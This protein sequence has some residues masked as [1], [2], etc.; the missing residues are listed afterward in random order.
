[1]HPDTVIQIFQYKIIHRTLACNEWLNNFK[2]KVDNSCLF[3]NNVD[4]ISHFLIDCSNNRFFLEMLCE[5][6]GTNDWFQ[7][8]R[9]K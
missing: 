1:M 5:M 9:R 6:V 8:K 2:I 4:S 7:H 3:C